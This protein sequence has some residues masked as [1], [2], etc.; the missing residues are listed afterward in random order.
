MFRRLIDL[1]LKNFRYY[2]LC[3]LFLNSFKK[4]FSGR[5]KLSIKITSEYRCV[6]VNPFYHALKIPD[7]S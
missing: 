1:E 7:L 3:L 5:F 2:D 4:R 6:N